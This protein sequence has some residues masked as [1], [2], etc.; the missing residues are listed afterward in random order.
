MTEHARIETDLQQVKA[1][2]RRMR[3]LLASAVTAAVAVGALLA[4]GRDAV[5]ADGGGGPGGKARFEE[6]EVQRIN[7]VE[8]DGRPRLVLSNKVRSPGAV[9]NGV[10][11]G[12]A[13]RRP[14]LTLYNAEGDES[15]GMGTDSGVDEGRPWASGQLAFDQYKQDQTLVLRYT[16][17]DGARGVGLA[18]H[19]RVD[20]PLDELLAE[21]RRIEA[22]PPGPERDRAQA[23]FR[24]KYAGPQRMFAGK[25]PDRA[26]VVTL[27]D[28]KGTPRLVLRVGHDGSPRIQFLDATGKVTRTIRG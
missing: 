1:Q 25:R 4:G 8:P 17:Q 13:G 10:D 3:V 22:M 26:S 15:G 28:A 24:Q 9:V 5:A 7:V 14:G 20:T 12:N 11:L 2:L 23:E 6:I 27:A 18:V 19:D 16:E 21:M